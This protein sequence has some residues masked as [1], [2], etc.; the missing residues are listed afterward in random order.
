[1]VE[2]Y[3][4]NLIHKLYHNTGT[5]RLVCSQLYRNVEGERGTR[6]QLWFCEE[7]MAATLAKS[8]HLT[9]ATVPPSPHPPP[10]RRRRR[11]TKMAQYIVHIYIYIQSQHKCHALH[12]ND[13][14]TAQYGSYRSVPF[15]SVPHTNI[16]HTCTQYV[17][18]KMYNCITN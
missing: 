17:T 5:R 7:G 3:D 15:R 2:N 1:M 12:A 11:E 10:Q 4:W 6:V 13:S 8:S 9:M 16:L 18:C 14:S